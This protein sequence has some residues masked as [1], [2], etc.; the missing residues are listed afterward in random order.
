[1]SFVK[2]IIKSID[3]FAQPITLSF[4]QKRRFST[5]VGGFLTLGM[6]SFLVIIAIN[7]IDDVLNHKNLTATSIEAI[8]SVPPSVQITHMFA[9]AFEPAA[10]NSLTG[11]VYFDFEVTL[12]VYSRFP[13]GT[14]AKDKSRKYSLSTCNSSHFP[15]FSQ[16]QLINYGISGWV[17]AN[18]PDNIE[19]AG[20][21]NSPIYK[22]IQIKVSKCGTSNIARKKGDN[23]S[24]DA[25]IMNFKNQNGGKIYMN[26]KYVN[27]LINL[28]NY[29]QPLIP[30]ID[31]LSF[32][33]DFPNIFLQK[34][35]SLTSVNIYTDSSTLYPKNDFS[36][37][38]HLRG[39]S[40]DGRIDEFA[41]NAPQNET[42]RMNYIALYFKS[43]A[44]NKTFQ[45]KYST[46]QDVVQLIGSF[47]SLCFALFGLFNKFLV[48][49]AFLVKLANSLYIFPM[50]KKASKP[51]VKNKLSCNNNLSNDN[52]VPK[53][54]KFSTLFT[55]I[56]GTK[57]KIDQDLTR[58]EEKRKSQKFKLDLWREM[59]AKFRG[60]ELEYNLNEINN[61]MS[62]ALDIDKILKIGNDLE[63]LKHALLTKDQEMLL[64]F[65]MK[66]TFWSAR[67]ENS[68]SFLK[69]QEKLKK[70]RK[71]TIKFNVPSIHDELFGCYQNIKEDKSETSKKIIEMLDD[72]L[73]QVFERNH[74]EEMKLKQISP[75]LKIEV[76]HSDKEI[77]NCEIPNKENQEKQEDIPNERRLSSI[78]I[79]QNNI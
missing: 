62:R 21:Y 22:F 27:Y 33:L 19:V 28:D 61:V 71:K 48:K 11:K 75:V 10:L 6:L 32:L 26:L 5:T 65:S 46:F 72:D 29:D 49:H 43:G 4:Y 3:A 44:K 15:M 58:L 68:M 50:Y 23:C 74:G 24:S 14:Q 8:A 63:R 66:P 73:I 2:K 20:D 56:S 69:Y 7:K 77:P 45:R 37:S 51:K 18:L 30:Y 64:N 35:L 1:M 59:K 57:K 9:F 34:E 79:S 76:D 78:I 38:D 70:K 36:S 12:P 60:E 39:S 42:G 53:K 41:L 17:C 31:Q 40:Y 52:I 47:W 67:N 25:E 13:N 16:Q 55:V 54:S